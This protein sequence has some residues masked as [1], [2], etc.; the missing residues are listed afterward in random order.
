M[1]TSKVY[2]VSY[3]TELKTVL[4]IWK[5][6]ATSKQFRE[7]SEALLTSIIQNQ[8]KLMLVDL[9]EMVIIGKDDQDWMDKSYIPQLIE[10]GLK[11]VAVVQPAYYFNKVAVESIIFNINKQLLHV[12]YFKSIEEAK[13]WLRDTKI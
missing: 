10:E 6:Y 7:G 8:A 5:G 9:K 11:A 12:N 4:G 13:D 3:D 2:S 1:D